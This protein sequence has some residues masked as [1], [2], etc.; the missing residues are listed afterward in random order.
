MTVPSILEDIANTE[1]TK[2]VV[3]LVDLNFLAFG[4]GLL[5]KSVG[6]KLLASGVKLLNH[7]GRDRDRSNSA[8]LYTAQRLRLPLFQD[9]E[10]HG[11]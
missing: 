9:K 2:D 10:G 7:Y 11:P 6:D 8:N 1:G 5:K 3:P 4:G